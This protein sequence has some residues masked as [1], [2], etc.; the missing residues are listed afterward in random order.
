MKS[1]GTAAESSSNE[2]C[3]A[4]WLATMS[5]VPTFRWWNFNPPAKTGC[6]T[7]DVSSMQ[8]ETEIGIKTWKELEI[9]FETEIVHS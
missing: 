2:C 8:K 5:I 9:M 6:N 3:Q 1:R 7:V 4:G